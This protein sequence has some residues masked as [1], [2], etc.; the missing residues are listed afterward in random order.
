MSSDA[1]TYHLILFNLST[2]KYLRLFCDLLKK[3]LYEKLI[4]N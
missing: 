1:L 3:L 2:F 4:K